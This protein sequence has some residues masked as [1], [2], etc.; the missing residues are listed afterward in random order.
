M[1]QKT[2]K[3][4]IH[5]F[6]DLEHLNHF[7]DVTVSFNMENDDKQVVPPNSIQS[8]ISLKPYHLV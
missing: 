1:Y 3:S 4:R 2:E 5:K 7:M 8:Y 6:K